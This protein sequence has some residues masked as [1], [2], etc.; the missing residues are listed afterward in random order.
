[1]DDDLKETNVRTTAA[2][3]LFT[4][5]LTDSAES[6]TPQHK[7]IAGSAGLEELGVL[8]RDYHKALF[9]AKTALLLSIA[10]SRRLN[11]RFQ[12]LI[13]FCS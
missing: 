8:F 11:L 3:I 4:S 10:R 2:N 7:A 12:N 5:D 1:M 9:P 13:K 6:A